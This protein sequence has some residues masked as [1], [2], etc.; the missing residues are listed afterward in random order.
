M[1]Y[2]A[3]KKFGYKI[4]I[5]TEFKK[6]LVNKIDFRSMQQVS[7]HSRSKLSVFSKTKFNNTG[8][9]NK[10][11][12]FGVIRGIIKFECNDEIIRG[13]FIEKLKC[14]RAMYNTNYICNFNLSEKI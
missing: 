11:I 12:G 7:F 2:N 10:N 6:A 1:K 3:L 9:F 8:I 5:L 14:I 4:N 13:I